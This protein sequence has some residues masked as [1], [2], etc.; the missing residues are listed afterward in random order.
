M[1]T[2]P[3]TFGVCAN[4]G[5]LVAGVNCRAVRCYPWIRHRLSQKMKRLP[6]GQ[7]LGHGGRKNRLRSVRNQIPQHVGLLWTMK[8]GLFVNSSMNGG[9]AM[10][11]EKG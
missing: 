7:V 8:E 10:G 3:F 4:S 1:E 2:V 6:E 11:V 9:G 5:Q